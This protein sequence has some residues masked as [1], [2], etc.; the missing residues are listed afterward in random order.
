MSRVVS[1]DNHGSDYPD[2]KFVTESMSEAE[3]EVT[4]ERMNEGVGDYSDRYY[5]VVPDDYKL[6][7]GFEP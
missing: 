2:E 1:T 5:I 4:A 7:P 3:A 6:V